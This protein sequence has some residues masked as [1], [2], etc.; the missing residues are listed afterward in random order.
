MTTTR[1]AKTPPK[2]K[3]ATRSPAKKPAAK[4]P[5]TAK[6]TA[7][8]PAAKKP[9][10]KK[11]ATTKLATKKPATAKTTAKE[12]AAK[13]VPVAS[14]PATVSDASIQRAGRLEHIGSLFVTESGTDSYAVFGARGP[15]L[16]S[17]GLRLT[18]ADLELWRRLLNE[19]AALGEARWTY[20]HFDEELVF[21]FEPASQP[22][23]VLGRVPEAEAARINPE[24]DAAEFTIFVGAKYGDLY[25]VFAGSPNDYA[26]DDY[27]G[28]YD[29]LRACG[30]FG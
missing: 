18:A 21:G 20:K 6:T 30:L 14:A 26:D 13:K 12:P 2:S 28:I 10:T 3:S 9:A 24:I 8:K 17:S 25:L 19:P 23:H 7:K 22:G 15:V 4:K 29:T 16:W 5:A 11:P 27:Q 1:I